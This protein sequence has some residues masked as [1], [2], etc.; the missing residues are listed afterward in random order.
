[1]QEVMAL[2]GFL[3]WRM[4]QADADTPA[5]TQGLQGQR[6]VVFVETYE[7]K[8]RAALQVGRVRV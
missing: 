8:D 1:M 5:K 2:P 3:A 6:R 7:L 4:A